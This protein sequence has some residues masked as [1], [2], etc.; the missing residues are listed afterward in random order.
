MFAAPGQWPAVGAYMPEQSPTS[1]QKPWRPS[2]SHGSASM[3]P[4]EPPWPPLPPVETLLIAPPAPP[5]PLEPS[6]PPSP[7]EVVA[8]PEVPTLTT[9][10]D[11]E[12]TRSAARARAP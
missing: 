3:E 11:R 4:P 5:E 6:L 9:Q 2:T 10:A 1:R 8:G 12:R 7:L